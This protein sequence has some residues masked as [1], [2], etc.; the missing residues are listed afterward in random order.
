MNILE[1]NTSKHCIIQEKLWLAVK[2][3]NGLQLLEKSS[4]EIQYLQKFKYV[5][6]S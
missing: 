3:L 1:N 5:L 4:R 2:V 6:P